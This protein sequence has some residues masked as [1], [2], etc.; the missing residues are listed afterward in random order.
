MAATGLSGFAP[1]AHGIQQF[2]FV[3]MIR[4]SGLPYYLGEG[5]LLGL[6]A[7]V[8]AVSLFSVIPTFLG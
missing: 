4:Q 6:G 7:V 8:Y 1:L 5:V 2:G 3:Q